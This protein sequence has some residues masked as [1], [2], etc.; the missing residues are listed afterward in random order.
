MAKNITC[1]K[2]EGELSDQQWQEI[3]GG[4][5]AR[6]CSYCGFELN[7]QKIEQ[8]HWQD[9]FRDLAREEKGGF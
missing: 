8:K 7:P 2:C 6:K 9:R 3:L 1:P 4:L 5:D